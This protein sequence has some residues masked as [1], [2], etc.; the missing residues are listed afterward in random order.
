MDNI[1]SKA[2]NYDAKIKVILDA[3]R[4]GERVCEL[5]GHKWQMSDEEISW[6]QKFQV[7]PSKM[8]PFTRWQLSS[9][10][11][12]GYQWWWQKHPETNKPILTGVHPATG[13]RVLPDEE[14][15][16]K[17]FSDQNRTYDISKSF[18]AQWH[19]LQKDIPSHATRNFKDPYNSITLVSNG[20]VE[21]Y[22]VLGCTSERS[23]YSVNST[24]RDSCLIHWSN[25]VSESFMVSDS[26]NVHHSRYVLDSSEIMD[27]DFIFSSTDLDHCFFSSNQ[28]HKKYLWMDKPISQGEYEKRISQLD[29]S[30]RSNI[31]KYEKTFFEYLQT[32]VIWP[33]Y[34]IVNAPGSSGEYIVKCLNCVHCYACANGARDCYWC[35]HAY[36]K[37]ERCAFVIGTYETE[38]GYY[39]CAVTESFKVKF[40]AYCRHCQDIEYCFNCIDCEN[41]FGCVGLSRKKFHIFNRLYEE[42]EYWKQVDELKCA[43]LERDEYG[44]FFPL[45][46]SPS[47]MPGSGPALYLL[48]DDKDLPK[49]GAYMFDPESCGAIGEDLSQSQNPTPISEIPDSID[50]LTDDWI[51]K[52]LLD[53]NYN[54]RFAFIKPEIEFY[55]KYRLAPP[56]DHFMYRVRNLM[57]LANGAVFEKQTCEKCQKEI[58][59]A[60]NKHFLKRRIY[61]WDCYLRYVETRE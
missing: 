30:R 5:T 7:P 18:F 15:F 53:T 55:R 48:T 28:H 16:S 6:Y 10:F 60:K 12:V 45:A 19:Q 1:V 38:E 9:G 20:D 27:S 21:S 25:H 29:F 2:P 47:Y 32:Q 11:Y 33:P 54:R 31:E 36:D 24:C 23:L 58:Q 56:N 35:I 61:C 46:F 59:V 52:P 49:L 41:C 39:S 4:P 26:S 13:I 57:W 44:E 14:W 8:S 50:D 40:S 43:M 22:F 3:T 34:V 42:E 51:N 17:D 37:A